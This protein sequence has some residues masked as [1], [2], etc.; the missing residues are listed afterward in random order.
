VDGL[1][2]TEVLRSVT[3][4]LDSGHDAR[5]LLTVSM[6]P[7]GLGKSAWWMVFLGPFGFAFGS[8]RAR[9]ASVLGP[10][11]ETTRRTAN[12]L[13]VFAADLSVVM[14]LLGDER[15]EEVA[16]GADGWG[17]ALWDGDANV[18]E[19]QQSVGR[20]IARLVECYSLLVRKMNR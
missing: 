18:E 3:A 16:A 9:R 20:V 15:L 12:A 19:L 7:G 4:A 17:T 14:P 5:G 1:N 10:T 6:P 11:R 13:D 8:E 2:P